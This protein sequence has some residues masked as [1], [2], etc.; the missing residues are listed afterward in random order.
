MVMTSKASHDKFEN[1]FVGSKEIND[2]LSV[3]DNVS[4][5]SRTSIRPKEPNY[6]MLESVPRRSDN[7]KS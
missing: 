1:A 5:R 4:E 3:V 7:L 2:M 6:V